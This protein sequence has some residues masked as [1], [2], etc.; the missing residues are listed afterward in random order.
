M[1]K[2]SGVLLSLIFIVVYCVNCTKNDLAGINIANFKALPSTVLVP[3]DN[4][5]SSQKIALGKMLFWDPILSGGKDIACATCHHAS[6]GYT[7]NLDLP[8]GS[9][10]IGLG[11]LRHFVL[12]NDIP[13]AKRNTP[14]IVNT[15]FNGMDANGTYNP[16][17]AAM[18]FDS[19]VKSLEL[20]SLEPIKTLE[21][22]SGHK[23]S[24]ATA[25]DSVMN[26]LK[27]IQEYVQMFNDAFGT[28]SISAANLG[29]AIASF[30][31]TIISNNSPYDK[32]I[33]GDATAM[34]G[35]QLQGMKAFQDNGCSN[36]H[37]GAMFSDY[38]L[39]VISAPDN[40]KLPT[41]AGAN[42]TYLFRTPSLRNL[43]L[44]APYMHSGVFN[45]LE[46]VLNFYD[47]V[48]DRR[49]QNPHVANNRLDG[50]LRRIN[51]NDRGLIIQFLNALND[52]SFDKTI[53]SR[54][55]SNLHVGGKI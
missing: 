32:Y 35:N 8:I 4:P 50:N 42:S 24:S 9:N 16:A 31:R 28:N 5:Q 1:R 44:T 37:S 46:Q 51:N 26:R 23:F 54:V 22:M 41:D 18:F 20:Q 36:C 48:G 2:K 3:A 47:Q 39:H 7:E 12:P 14:T 13:F 52:N 11:T 21:E 34:S 17:T 43:A 40:P 45:S 19:R 15:A 25:L 30:E 49:S 38:Q 33:R 53:P 55:A 27:G 10:G 6:L 29:K